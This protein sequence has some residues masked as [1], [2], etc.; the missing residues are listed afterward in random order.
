MKLQSIYVTGGAV[1]VL[2]ACA[3]GEAARMLPEDRSP[4]D[5]YAA[6]YRADPGALRAWEEASRRALR[7]GRR[8]GPSLRERVRFPD[9]DAHAEAWRFHLVR[10]QT[11]RVQVRPVDGG[12]PL[13]MDVFQHLG[14]D[15]LRPARPARRSDHALTF[16]ARASGEFVLRLQ[17]R[18][19]SGG[20]YDVS[21]EGDAQ[22]QFPV[23]GGGLS[24]IGGVFGDPRDGG[25]REHEGV[26]IFAPRGTAVVAVADGWIEQARHTPTGGVVIWQHDAARGLR[27]YYAHLDALH[28][29]EGERV[30]AGDVIGRVG[31]TG[32]ARGTP[33]HLHFGVYQPGTIPLDP[34]PMIA[35]SAA[36]SDRRGVASDRLQRQM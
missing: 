30:S 8:A 10:G 22:L 6:R 23:A 29:R 12:S 13:F 35:G 24:D 7:T 33:P 31:N 32:N 9:R 2:A 20:E 3:T 4:R 15:V 17:P 25:A 11:L 27:Y 34:L 21:V 16:V 1:L 36:P 18:I 26:D 5:V 14:G 19:G 28:V